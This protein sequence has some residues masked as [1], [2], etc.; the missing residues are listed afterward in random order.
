MLRMLRM[1]SNKRISWK[2]PGGMKSATRKICLK[3]KIK[4]KQKR[5]IMATKRNIDEILSD[6]L[7]QESK[8]SYQKAWDEFVSYVGEKERPLEEDFLQ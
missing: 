5:T 7:P 1:L 4:C 8:E 6:T 2:L 3:K